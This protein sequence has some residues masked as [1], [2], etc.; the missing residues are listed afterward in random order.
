MLQELPI[1]HTLDIMHIEKNICDSILKFLLG[2][3]DTPAVQ[4]DFRECGI[5]RR[6]WL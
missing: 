3:K 2:E 6:L 4:E 5:S 1:C